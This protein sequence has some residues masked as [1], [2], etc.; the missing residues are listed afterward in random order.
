MWLKT[1]ELY[2]GLMLTINQSSNR[3]SE[4]F[5]QSNQSKI[6]FVQYPL[7]TMFGVFERISNFIRVTKGKQN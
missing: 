1:G 3:A 6:L 5:F 4:T 7:A 2:T